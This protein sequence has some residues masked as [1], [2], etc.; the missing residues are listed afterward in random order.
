MKPFTRA[1]RVG[2]LIQET[3]SD[4]LLRQI[5]DPRLEMTII[6]KVKMSP[7]LKNAHVFFS[8]SGGTRERKQE[9][10]QGFNSAIGYIKRELARELELR[11]MPRLK[12]SYDD[13]FDYGAHIEELL[14]QVK[15]EEV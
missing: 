4:I 11:Y 10:H 15:E 3:L 9:A 14:K 5:K 7:D 12:F 13:S 8:T 6:T 1:D 2:R